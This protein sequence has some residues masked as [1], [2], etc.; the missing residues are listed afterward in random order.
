MMPAQ[1][2][3]YEMEAGFTTIVSDGRQAP[4]WLLS[5]RHGRFMPENH[6]AALDL[7]VHSL[8]DP[9]GS[10]LFGYGIEVFSRASD[11]S[12]VHL[13]QA[14]GFVRWKELLYLR[15]GLW[16]DVVGSIEPGLSSGSVIWSGNAR[17]LPRIEAG[18]N[19]YVEVP[20]TRGYVEFSGLLSH[21]WFLDDRYVSNVLFHN[22]N[23]YMRIGGPL[24]INIY[25]GFNHY[26]QWGGQSPDYELPFPS[27]LEAYLRIFF[28]HSGRSDDPATP[29]T[30]ARHKFGNTLGSRNHG[31]DFKFDRAISGI[32]F[33]DVFE[34]GSGL[35]MK[36]FP[37]GLWGGY[38]RFNEGQRLLQAVVYEILHTKDQSGP[39]HND[40]DG[41]IIGGNDN[42]FNHGIY[43]SGWTNHGFT[44]GTP[45]ITSPV[46][47]RMPALSGLTAY[48]LHNNRVLVHH[49]GLEGY[50]LPTT[51]YRALIS[52]SKNHGRHPAP[53]DPPLE[54]LSV[55]LEASHVITQHG[56]TV[57]LTL[58]ADAGR[59]YG[60]N[61][62]F[63]LGLR[64]G[65]FKE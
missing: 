62:G 37:D 21:G 30:W 32:Y 1:N 19:G 31:L 15:G 29:G 64:K 22:K 16:E 56:L 58:A 18:T 39:T 25:Y 33:Q 34:D 59:M 23:A 6:A 50:L 53:F 36:N 46:F 43:R 57:M 61:Y 2:T 14:Y 3:S 44:L 49:L 11:D 47:N 45:F 27:D 40:P 52:Y 7:S 8:V 48:R 17:P 13:Q 5:N 55:M 51:R 42:Y 63:M 9:G 60:D 54:Q 10:F 38:L 4:F 41:N 65:W 12:R 20:Y 28:N 35:R 26:A 24:R